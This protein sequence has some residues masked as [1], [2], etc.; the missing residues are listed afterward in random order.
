M[1]ST[2]TRSPILSGP[3]RLARRVVAVL[4]ECNDAQRR[5]TAISTAPD[6][7]SPRPDAA[8]DTD[9]EF[10]FRTSGLLLHEPSARSRARGHGAL[11]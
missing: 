6:R 1:N 8:P 11:R 9:A 7:Y 3:G 10:L 4:R 5:M 2:N